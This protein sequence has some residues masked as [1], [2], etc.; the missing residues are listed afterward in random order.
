M[1][2]LATG[3]TAGGSEALARLT[4]LAQRQGERLT[5][6]IAE[7]LDAT[8]IQGGNLVLGLET[9]DLTRLV[10]GVV[11]ELEEDVRRA[12]ST[13]TLDAPAA[14]AGRWDGRRLEQVVVNL[15]TNA[16][17]FG[18]GQPITIRL[19]E[20]QGLACLEVEDQG[21][22]IEPARQAAV[23]EPFV[24]AVAPLHYG[25]LGLGLFICRR[26]VEA[27]GGA[28]T[29]RSSPGQ[30]ST[31]VVALPVRGP[32]AEGSNGSCR[33]PSRTSS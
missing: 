6:L 2:E 26:I 15:V 3:V 14:L 30:G 18:E 32:G 27:H 10:S 23:F 33:P 19:A 12:G 29:V 8:R 5:R 22:G 21:I 4:R 16:L 20:R 9:V 7:L 24:Q 31:F 13:V 1:R 25:G 28:I 11:A 17:K